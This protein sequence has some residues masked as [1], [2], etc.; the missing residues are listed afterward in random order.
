MKSF[1]VWLS[2]GVERDPK[3]KAWFAGSILKKSN[4]KPIP[5]YHGTQAPDFDKFKATGSYKRGLFSFSLDPTLAQEYAGRYD[6]TPELTKE[7]LMNFPK[8]RVYEVYLNVKKPFDFRLNDHREMLMQDIFEKVN[9]FARNKAKF[10]DPNDSLG[11]ERG[12]TE[13]NRE[14][15]IR[16]YIGGELEDAFKKIRDGLWAYLE[17]PDFLKKHGF[18]SVYTFEFERLNIHVLSEDQIWVNKI[19]YNRDVIK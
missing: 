16:M 17:K 19:V 10:L 15:R 18:D 2:E 9:D 11:K 13:E 14:V 7:R 4:G 6:R 8:G 12:V 1:S 5:V 3:F